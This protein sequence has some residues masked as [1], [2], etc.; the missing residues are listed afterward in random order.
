[1]SNLSFIVVSYDI[2]DDRRRRRVA[3]AMENQGKRVQESVFECLLDERRLLKL[4]RKLRELLD[5]EVDSVRFYKLCEA[6]RPRIETLGQ[7]PP[8]SEP[9][10]V[11]IV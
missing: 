1:M 8:A 11:I 10:N 3:K 5:Q 9:T 2:A 7:G 4:Q 6:C